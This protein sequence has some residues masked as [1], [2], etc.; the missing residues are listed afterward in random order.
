AAAAIGA[1]EVIVAIDRGNHTGI[2][3]VASAIEERRR[4]GELDAPASVVGVPPRFV[5]GEERALAAFINGGDAKPTA[6]PP[7][8]FERGVDGRPTFVGNVE[9]LCHL[10]QIVQWGAAWFRRVGTTEEPGSLLSTVTG[11]VAR[12]GVCEV[13]FGTPIPTVVG[14]AGGTP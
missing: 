11:D 13:A 5:A 1:N 3:A 9:T 8:V 14:A 2:D 6:A 4:A 7:R 10:A 12:P